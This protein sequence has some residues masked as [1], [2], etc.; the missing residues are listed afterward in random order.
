MVELI[1]LFTLFFGEAIVNIWTVNDY[2][3]LR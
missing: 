1:T 3:K 2:D